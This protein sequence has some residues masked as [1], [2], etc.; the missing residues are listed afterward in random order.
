MLSSSSL[1]GPLGEGL[2]TQRAGLLSDVVNLGAVLLPVEETGGCASA[3]DGDRR[4][5]AVTAGLTT[6]LCHCLLWRRR[7]CA[8]A[9]VEVLPSY[10]RL[11]PPVGTWLRVEHLG[12]LH[13][14]LHFLGPF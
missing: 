9:W 5:G 8:A 12:S 4:A 11:G 2:D 7:K 10:P 6:G 3:R 1:A 13:F 14:H